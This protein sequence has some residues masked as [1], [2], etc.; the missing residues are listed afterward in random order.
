MEGERRGW[1]RGDEGGKERRGQGW[2]EREE[3]GR[4]KRIGKGKRERKKEERGGEILRIMEVR[5]EGEGKDREW[6]RAKRREN[7]GDKINLGF[8]KEKEEIG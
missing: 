3:M 7:G 6:E 5:R 1:E 2:R 8:W 4:R